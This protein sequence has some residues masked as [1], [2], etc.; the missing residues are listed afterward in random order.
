MPNFKGRCGHEQGQSYDVQ[1]DPNLVYLR[2]YVIMISYRSFLSYVYE[3]S[4]IE[5]RIHR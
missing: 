1:S 5:M 4:K 3:D 2:R